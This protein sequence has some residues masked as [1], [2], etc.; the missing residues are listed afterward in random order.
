MVNSGSA[1]ESRR[2]FVEQVQALDITRGIDKVRPPFRRAGL[3]RPL[4][5][6]TTGG[7]TR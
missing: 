3:T 7:E 6:V 1:G 5:A 4:A 2:F